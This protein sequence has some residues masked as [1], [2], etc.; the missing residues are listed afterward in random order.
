MFICKYCNK[1]CKNKNSLANHE[2]CCTSNPNRNYRNGMLGKKGSNQFIKAKENG[3]SIT[4]PMKGKSGKK[5]TEEQ[6][7]NL[8][9]IAKNRGFGGYRENAGRSKK[10]KVLDSYGNFVVLQ[11]SYE[12]KC[13]EILNELDIKW[14]RPKSLDYNT[15]KKY[16]A[17]FYLPEFDI[18]LDPKNPYKTKLDT[19]KII[20]VREQNKIKLFVLQFE[21]LTPDYI[22]SL[23]S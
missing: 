12:L 18:W 16:F 19:E 11:S 10:Y 14:L 6:K 23:C 9:I 7:K 22:K 21:Q 3:I 5:L 13:A 2:R 20:N 4:H 8:S 15:N 1:E 17:D